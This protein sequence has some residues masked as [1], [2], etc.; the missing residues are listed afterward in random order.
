MPDTGSALCFYT[1][2]H[3]IPFAHTQLKK[4]VV[5]KEEKK[6]GACLPLPQYTSTSEVAASARPGGGGPGVCE[7]A[8][9]SVRPSTPDKTQKCMAV[10]TAAAAALIFF[11][12]I[13]AHL[14][15]AL[16]IF[17]FYCMHPGT[18]RSRFINITIC[19]KEM[20]KK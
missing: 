11:Y 14:A 5:L 18:P 17:Y 10:L 16:L 15:T 12:Y 2:S 6:G 20:C 8:R 19:K 7:R 13:L 1:L 9:A 4:V 3:C